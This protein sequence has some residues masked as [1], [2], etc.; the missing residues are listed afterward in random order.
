MSEQLSEEQLKLIWKTGFVDPVF[1]ARTVLKE[2]FPGDI[3]WM[4]RGLFAIMRRKCDFLEKYG[5]L[6]KIIRHFVYRENPTDPKS[7]L[8]PIFQRDET[9]KLVMHL[10]QNVN[11]IIPRGMAKTTITNA[12]SIMDIVYQDIQFLVLVSE[13]GTHAQTQLRNIRMQLES[14]ALLINVFGNLVPGRQD[15]EK[16]TDDQL[17]TTTR[18]TVVAKGRGAQI[19]GLNDDGR[20][21]DKIVLDDMEDDESVST[22][23]QRAKVRKLF[24]GAIMPALS[25]MNKNATI[26]CLG[27]M[28]HPD[29]LLP[30]LEKSALFTSIKF[31]VIDQDGES[32]WEANM[33]LAKIKQLEAEYTLGGELNTFNREYLSVVTNEATQKFKIEFV[34]HLDRGLTGLVGRA[35]AV[36]PAISQASTADFFAL[37]VVSMYEG[38]NLQVEEIVLKKGLLPSEQVDLIFKVWEEWLKPISMSYVGIESIAYQ[39]ALVHLVREEMFRRGIYFEVKPLTNRERKIERVEGILQKRYASGYVGH[40]TQFPIYEEQLLNWPSGKKDGPDVIAMA[41][42]L[43]DPLAFVAAGDDMSYLTKPLEPMEYRNAAESCP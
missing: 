15:S 28:L 26:I 27:T 14:N 29:A 12:C 5:E 41:V 35:L 22:P 39:A 18:V 4:H 10:G 36:D 6:D 20:R 23:E 30:T 32:L 21:P 38:G 2:W 37:G 40:R 13:S 16:W 24:Y 9:G 3:P 33:P 43:L 8:L 7:K 11:C 1:F 19:R 17:Q 42:S 31:G 25:K 34:K